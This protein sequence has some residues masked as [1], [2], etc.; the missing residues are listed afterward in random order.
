MRRRIENHGSIKGSLIFWN[1]ILSIIREFNCWSI[2]GSPL[3]GCNVSN[4]DILQTDLNKDIMCTWNE[5]D[6]SIQWN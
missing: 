3:K 5:F 2:Q 4:D 6:H 1:L